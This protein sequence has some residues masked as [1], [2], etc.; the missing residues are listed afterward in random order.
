MGARSQAETV[1][2][3]LIAF[4]H[5]RTWQQAELARHVE[6]TTRRLRINLLELSR[7]GIPLE[8][9]TEH[10]HVYWSVP[11][12]WF[13]AGVVLG[14]DVAT[15]VARLLA[16]LPDGPDRQLALEAVLEALPSHDRVHSIVVGLPSTEP[17][18][19]SV[20]QLLED[21]A[22]AQVPVRMR[23]FS[24]SRGDSTVRLVSVHRFNYQGPI[25]FVATCHRSDS[26]KWFRLDRVLHATLA[27]ADSYRT[28]VPG[29]IDDF[30]RSSVG[31][32]RGT[33]PPA[34][35]VCFVRDPE[36]RWVARNLPADADLDPVSNGV[37][38]TW[39]S[40][41]LEALA[42]FVVGLGGAATARTPALRDAVVTLAAG[43]LG[44]H[45][46][47]ADD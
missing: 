9:E 27:S 17:T 24:V 39:H 29:T 28:V 30:V 26:L 11:K 16:R 32:F 36:A 40:G 10:P 1:A 13:P 6:L 22:R 46:S 45:A 3:I 33:D 31:G 43:A 12:A 4:L 41:G 15:Q 47:T 20:L 23:Y 37:V 7:Q 14:K 44:A 42:R 21:G 35:H 34:T 18:P 2:S 25:R 8:A 19:A 5:Q 38:L